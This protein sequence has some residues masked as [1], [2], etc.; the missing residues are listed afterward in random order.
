MKVNT[1]GNWRTL[2]KPKTQS[3]Y[4][5]DA[6]DVSLICS[7]SGRSGVNVKIEVARRNVKMEV[8]TGAS[9]SVVLTQMYNKFYPTYSRR[10]ALSNFNH[11]MVN[12]R[13]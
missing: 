9:V 6:E 3:A 2:R 1:E 10:R 8:D 7:S 12:D 11:I 13:R 5:V 4:Q